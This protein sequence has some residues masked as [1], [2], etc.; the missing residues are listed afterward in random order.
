[1]KLFPD[2]TVSY[3]FCERLKTYKTQNYALSRAMG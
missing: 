3:L 1:M 2:K